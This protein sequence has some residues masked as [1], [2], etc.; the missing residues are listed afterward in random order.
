MQ[1][2][3]TEAEYNE[4]VSAK[5][6]AVNKVLKLTQDLTDVSGELQYYKAKYLSLL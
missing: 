6:K 4:L 2:I 5:Q 3:L 1:Y